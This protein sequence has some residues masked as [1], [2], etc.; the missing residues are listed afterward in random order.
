MPCDTIL[1]AIGQVQR[2]DWLPADCAE[3]GLVKADDYGRLP[4]PS[5][6]VFTGGDVMRGPSMVVDALGDGKRA[7]RDIDRVLSAEPLRPEDPVEVMPYEKLNTAYF[8]H[9]PRTEA[10]LAPA[11]ARRTSQVT[12]VTLA[13]SREQALA[14][15][16][17]CMSCGVCN[18][19]DNCYIVCP[20]VSVLRDARQ[21]GHYSIRTHYC[22]GCLVC[23][24]ECPT[25]CLE[26]VPELDFDEPGD[27]VRMETAFAPYDGAHAEQAPFTR[28]LI[29]DAIAEYDRSRSIRRRTGQVIRHDHRAR[30]YPAGPPRLQRAIRTPEG[31]RFLRDLAGT[32]VR[33]NGCAAAAYAALYANVDVITAYPIRPYTAIMMNLA[34]FVADGILDAEYLHADG[35]HSQFSAAFGAG[36]CGARAYT[37]SS[38]VGVTYGYEMYSIISGARIPIQ[39]AIANR[40]LDPPGD[41][42]SEHTDALCTRDMG[43]LMGWAATPQE[44]FDKSLLGYAIGEDPRVLLPQMV[45]QDGYFVSHIAGEVEM[46]A[47]EQVDEFLPPYQL[48]FPLDPRRPVSHGPQIH[49]EQGPPLQLERARAMEDAIPVIRE[50]TDEFARVFGRQYPHFVESYLLED[51]DIAL[52]IS[53]GHAVTCRAAVNRMR[54]QG[55]KIGMARLL[56]VRPFPGDDLR[57]GA[58]RRQGGRGGGDQPR[59]RRRQLRRHPLAGRDHRAVPPGRPASAGDV[60]HG[61]PGRRDRADGRV[62]LDG[63]QARPGRRAR[64]GG[65]GR[66]LGRLRGLGGIEMTHE[67]VRQTLPLF[68]EDG[69][70]LYYLPDLPEEDPY[71]AGHRTCAGCG[72]AIQYR[73]VLKAAGQ[74]TVV[75][76][77]TG[78]MYVANS[79]YLCTPY[80]VPWAHTPIASGGSFT[81]GVAA[82][83][84]AMI[85][86][87]RYPGPYPNIL[88]MAGDGSAADIGL[89]S[90]SGALYRN[91]DALFVCY[92]NECYA[93]TGI[94]T[95]PTTPYAGMT[96]FTPFG[97][98]IPE[99]KK[100]PPKNLAKM[101]AEGHPH[102][103]VATTTVGYPI[104]L[105]NKT[106]KGLNHVGAAFLHCY[107]PCQKGWVYQTSM[108]VELGRRVVESGLFPVWEYDPHER[109]YRYFHPPV[110]RPVTDYL[111]MQGRFGHMLPE[112]V[113]TTQVA[114]NRNWE[115]IGMEVPKALRDL[116]DPARH[117]RLADEEYSMPIN[118]GVGA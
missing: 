54:E 98:A 99:G 50:K 118:R 82:G 36:S 64:P 83:Y 108:T 12:E 52:V 80:T 57:R 110:Q 27:V 29:E 69:R 15:A 87:G 45:V 10:P 67:V 76:G 56:W 59:P 113:A 14:E 77:P 49:P 60:V 101:M 33:Q 9:A 85:R 89:G 106:R 13:Y 105:M 90:I 28:R 62:R 39:M 32:R 30:R 3:R 20:D 21:N 41:F 46:P 34:Q 43:W 95:S 25:G 93:N 91:H 104:D 102:C 11:A 75:A 53:G 81:S 70:D 31:E 72:P 38:G 111:A 55:I 79:T 94:Q 6:T 68:E 74:D 100:L 17:R 1:V 23:V 114:A 18:G 65:E 16:D 26:R 96:T 66:P 112:H 117:Q 115:A 5:G 19:C 103:Y 61:R 63:R 44:V 97:K 7:A 51:A 109:S 4:H 35:E 73:W 71:A 84:E 40:T 107:T 24:Q 37:G 8:R 47:A 2:L 48:P 78:C 92:D 22:K 116:E 42:G 58:G 88:V 86:K